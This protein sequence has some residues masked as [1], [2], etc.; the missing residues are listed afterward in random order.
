M[1]LAY[2]NKVA[3]KSLNKKANDSLKEINESALSDMEL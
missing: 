1:L 2:N 3:T